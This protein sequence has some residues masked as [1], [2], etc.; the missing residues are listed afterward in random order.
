MRKFIAIISQIFFWFSD[1]KNAPLVRI[2]LA[3]FVFALWFKIKQVGIIS[4]K[5]IWHYPFTWYIVFVVQIFILFTC[6]WLLVT[7]LSTLFQKNRSFPEA[8]STFSWPF[9]VFVLSILNLNLFYQA[10]CFVLWVIYLWLRPMRSDDFKRIVEP[11]LVLIG[12][13]IILMIFTQPFSP[14]YD[15]NFFIGQWARA[16]NFY[17]GLER[18]IVNA[19]AYEFIGSFTQS[20]ILGGYPI[21]D[22]FYT[23]ELYSVLSLIFDIP[24]VDLEAKYTLFQYIVMGL[25]ILAS[26]G[27][28]AFFRFG[29]GLRFTPSFIGGVGFILGNAALIAFNGNEFLLHYTDLL[30]LPWVFLCIK[31]AYVKQKNSLLALAGLIASLGE[32][33][34]SDHAIGSLLTFL[35]ILFY[36]LFLAFGEINLTQPFILRKTVMSFLKRIVVLPVFLLIG[37]SLRLVPLF[38]AI[39]SNDYSIFSPYP[40]KGFM[41]PGFISHLATFFFRNATNEISTNHAN[42]TG[43]HIIFYTGP[44]IL[45]L[46]FC[47]LVYVIQQRR[48]DEQQMGRGSQA[49]ISEAGFFL[50]MLVFWSMIIWGGKNSFLQVFFEMFGGRIHYFQ[51]MNTFFFFFALTSAMFGLHA[52]ISNK[53]T[54]LLNY[55]M[56]VYLVLAITVLSLPY[57]LPSQVQNLNKSLIIDISLLF[58][59]YIGLLICLVSAN[60]LFVFSILLIVSLMSFMNLDPQN[61]F[62]RKRQSISDEKTVY[63]SFRS[64]VAAYRNNVHDR[65]CLDYLEREWSKF[66][67]DAQGTNS[68]MRV[69]GDT[70]QI[71]RKEFFEQVAPMVDR[72]YLNDPKTIVRTEFDRNLPEIPLGI[73]YYNAVQYYLPDEFSRILLGYHGSYPFNIPIGK[74]SDIFSLKC[75]RSFPSFPTKNIY[76][77]LKELMM[78]HQNRCGDLNKVIA[79]RSYRQLL[80]ILG[81]D[82]LIYLEQHYPDLEDKLINNGFV[83]VPVSGSFDQPVKIYRNLNSYGVAYIAYWSKRM[84]PSSNL[85]NG[86]KHYNKWM[87]SKELHDNVRKNL[88]LIPENVQ[89]A[90][91]IEDPSLSGD[92]Q[93]TIN[94][95]DNTVDI[96]KIIGSKAAFRVRCQDE[97][98]WFVYNIA[99]QKG[100]TVHDYSKSLPIY[101][102]NIGFIG[103][104][105]NKGDHFVWMEYR[106]FSYTL[107]FFI[108]F[109]GWI[110]VLWRVFVQ[111][112]S[113]V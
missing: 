20:S 36:N 37:L 97:P 4:P 59:S 70:S 30:F 68:L 108:T 76:F 42:I 93:P 27:M 52:L 94:N 12:L 72:F 102:A 50:F 58:L 109:V 53:K 83:Q 18:Q 82:Y 8:L 73:D 104:Q 80:N 48:E 112:D 106:P 60:R 113:L 41:W 66:Q 75:A 43:S 67:S 107:G 14:L 22:V 85:L 98:C 51:R 63:T 25:Y 5:L 87:Y 49:F 78:E 105:L 61:N 39:I 26:F 100:W 21:F 81:V 6:L 38:D 69:G 24:V 103:V 44:F 110:M 29:A 64:A 79:N 17:L 2:G 92:E 55:S 88:S 101:K 89:R 46:C 40:D 77:H 56:V 32:Y 7:G 28:Y 34:F 54:S 91:L 1:S 33:T 19:K 15:G 74:Y 99:Y 96:V 71:P 11:F 111:S 86:Y 16:D 45:L 35:I 95:G 10:L 47:L 13:S 9:L 90:A 23:S 3:A 62:L 65:A 57:I 31:L 84:S